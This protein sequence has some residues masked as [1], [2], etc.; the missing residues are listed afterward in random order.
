VGKKEGK[1]REKRNS[2]LKG[3]MPKITVFKKNVTRERKLLEFSN[4]KG[5]RE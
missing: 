2:D 4:V 1:K 3:L 5:T